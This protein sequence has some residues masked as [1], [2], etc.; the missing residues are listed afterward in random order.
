MQHPAHLVIAGCDVQQVSLRCQAGSMSRP[1]GEQRAARIN[2]PPASV[3]CPCHCCLVIY[4]LRASCAQMQAAPKSVAQPR[5]KV[6][7]CPSI[8]GEREE[9]GTW[10]PKLACLDDVDG[11]SAGWTTSMARLVEDLMQILSP[12]ARPAAK[13]LALDLEGARLGGARPRT[14]GRRAEGRGPPG[15]VQRRTDS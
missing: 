7:R 13:A 15:R 2:T 14:P 10:S 9:A 6:P 12:S 3:Q 11:L 8:S 1:A 4:V 5:C